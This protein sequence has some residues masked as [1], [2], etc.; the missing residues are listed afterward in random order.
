[1]PEG[2]TIFRAARTLEKAIGEQIVTG[3]RSSLPKLYDIDLV[4]QRITKIEAR[5]KNLL[6][7]FSDARVLHTH[8]MMTG[9]WHIYRHGEKWQKTERS[10]RVVI[11]TSKWIA[12]CFNAPVVELL[13]EVRIKR[14]EH[15]RN[16]GPDILSD[17]FDKEEVLRRIHLHPNLAIGEVL[18]YQHV[19][20]GIGNI[21]K[22]ETL[23]LC[24]TNPF[25][26]VNNLNE[27]HLTKIIERAR[28]LMKANL[29]NA[30]RITRIGPSGGRMWVYGR[31]GE[32]CFRCGEK[33][34]KRTQGAAQRSTFWCPKCQP[35]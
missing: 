14:D 4:G 15:L 18:L 5:G 16:L 28:R 21:Y 1:M 29:T 24:H 27:K 9:S 19:V 25:V 6:I 10:A 34:Q 33:I 3:F 20:A 11:E 13:S 8:M 35:R 30:A 7:H 32:A 31:A 23:F 2:D 12:V 26:V 17:G 22:S